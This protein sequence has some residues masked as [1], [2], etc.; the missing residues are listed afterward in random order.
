[1]ASLACENL[2]GAE[3]GQRQKLPASPWAR[4]SC[5]P[6]PPNTP[7]ATDHDLHAHLDL[8]HFSSLHCSGF[9]PTVTPE[10][11]LCRR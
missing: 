7:T 9:R 8:G 5:P 3:A 11:H 2:E 10:P 4:G 1:M 6:T